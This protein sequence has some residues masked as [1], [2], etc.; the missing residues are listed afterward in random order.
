[1]GTAASPIIVAAGRE[2]RGRDALALGEDLARLRRAPL[3]LAGVYVSLLGRAAAVYEPPLR[4][5]LAQE[6]EA[7]RGVAGH[8]AGVSLLVV[9]SSSVA[10][11]LHD[12]AEEV[13]A[14]TLV[15]GPSHL[16][17]KARLLRGDVTLGAIQAAPCAVAV[18]P[19]GYAAEPQRSIESIAVA[20]DGS[21]EAEQALTSAT[22]LARQAGGRLRIVSALERPYEYTDPP[23][24]DE[25]GH[26]S[27][28][29][30]LAGDVQERLEAAGRRVAADVPVTTDYRDGYAVA[31]LTQ[32]TAEVD[33][34]VMGSRGYGPIRRTLLGSV[35]TGVIEQTRCPVLVLP[36]GAS[37]EPGTPPAATTTV[38][39]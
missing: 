14:G 13:G 39:A 21:P 37:V 31:E 29:R 25:E 6:L 23:V 24:I 26:K 19:A 34:L 3:V 9:G 15:I 16:G 10:R 28:L 35:A 20:Y 11:G 8:E 7:L 1:M 27:Y 17:P 4:R 30:S 12:A 22:D 5:E 2:E 33:L 36:R 32:V 18:A 38:V